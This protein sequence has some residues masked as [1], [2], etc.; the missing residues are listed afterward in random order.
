MKS[1]KPY[2]RDNLSKKKKKTL[3]EKNETDLSL[4]D[5]PPK[6]LTNIFKTFDTIKISE[7]RCVFFLL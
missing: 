3:K 7:A 1:I 4:A 2:F 6:T 5:H